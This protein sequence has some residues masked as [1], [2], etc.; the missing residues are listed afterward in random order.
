[1]ILDN[2]GY[3]RA[4]IESFEFRVDDSAT[5]IWQG[6]G[7]EL[8]YKEN[9]NVFQLSWPIWSEYYATYSSVGEFAPDYGVLRI[10]SGSDDVF[11]GH[12]SSGLPVAFDLSEAASSYFSFSKSIQG[13][14]ST[15][16]Q[17]NGDLFSFS[18]SDVDPDPEPDPCLIGD[19]NCDGLVE[20]GAD[21]LTTFS[22]FTGPGSFDMT[23]A[24]GDVHGE[25]TGATDDPVGHD[26]DVDVNDI[27]TTFTAF[28]AGASDEAGLS[29]AQAGDPAIPDLIYDPTTGEVVLDVDG[30]AII[31][32]SLK[33]AGGFLAG[34]H[35]PILGGVTT[36]LSTELAEAALSSPSGQNSVGF[37]FPVGLDLAGL[38]ALLTEN[39]VSTGLGAP[40]VPFDLV[41][42]GPAVP[43]PSAAVLAASAG[44]AGL[45]ALRKKR[46]GSSDKRT[47]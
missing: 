8:E 45:L 26:G 43:E 25:G 18:G 42:S 12:H 41:V 30:A 35:T 23:R 11:T 27:L 33:S 1:M 17:I 14:C 9:T 29:P 2:D 20:V 21:I 13:T 46:Q 4:P 3:W 40:L 5:E 32:Y 31:G 22:N 47:T 44:L 39:T 10:S 24:D 15:E 7:G 36:S 34:A 28:G 37:V 16:F 19:V 6:V 38:N